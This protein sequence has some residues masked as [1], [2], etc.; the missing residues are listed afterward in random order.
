MELP[1]TMRK[2]LEWNIIK[3]M[4]HPVAELFLNED[5]VKQTKEWIREIQEDNNWSSDSEME[6]ITAGYFAEEVFEFIAL[7]KQ[8]KQIDPS[9]FIH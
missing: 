5:F 9:C 2:D 1:K 8:I 4:R 3:F 7:I 6:S